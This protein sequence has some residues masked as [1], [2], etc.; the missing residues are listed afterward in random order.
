MVRS[1]LVALLAFFL[2]LRMGGFPDIDA[3]HSSRWQS[4]PILIALAAMVE[5]TRCMKR[6]WSFYQ[7][8]ILL[9]LYTDVMIMGMAV[10][11]FFFP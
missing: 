6:K 2:S 7:A 1:T 10:F 5:T 8:G 4:L 9:L 11:L 3:L